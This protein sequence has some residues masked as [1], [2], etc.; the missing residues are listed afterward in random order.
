MI[1][2]K[3]REIA[4]GGMN[5]ETQQT[6]IRTALKACSWILHNINEELELLSDLC[7]A[8]EIP[9]NEQDKRNS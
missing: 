7:V 6:L 2:D 4:F 8:N 3:L 9:V 5:G 1:N